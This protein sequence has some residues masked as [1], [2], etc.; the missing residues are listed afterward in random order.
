MQ[1]MQFARHL[2]RLLQVQEE[3]GIFEE[4]EGGV[5]ASLSNETG[6]GSPLH[7]LSR[8]SKRLV[9]VCVCMC[10]I[11]IFDPY[12]ILFFLCSL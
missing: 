5:S 11:V 4:V 8:R 9:C 1:D 6:A 7:F 3:A 10:V 12:L 2:D